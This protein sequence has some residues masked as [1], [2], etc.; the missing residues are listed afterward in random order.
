M[1]RT[2][3][4]AFGHIYGE[5]N[6]AEDIRRIN[7]II[8]K[9]MDAV[10]MREELTELK[11]RSDY[12]CTLTHSPTWRKRF[13]EKVRALRRVAMEENRKTVEHA[14]RVA[15]Q[16]GWDADYDPWG[17]N[18]PRR[19]ATHERPSHGTARYAA[20]RGGTRQTSRVRI[21]YKPTTARY[22]GGGKVKY[23]VYRSPQPLRTGAIQL[24]TRVKRL[25][26][27]RSAR[28][29]RVEA[30]Q[31]AVTRTGK[32]VYGVVVRYEERLGPTRARRNSTTY[33]LPARWVE[34]TKVVALPRHAKNVRLQDRAPE[35]PLLAVA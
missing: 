5:V 28:R 9:E 22:S 7:R 16:H 35:G 2:S 6:S 19:R 8:R 30:P 13:G 10:T 23:L 21:H 34:R 33:T 29:I 15:A 25:Y 18:E 4:K 32:R 31:T 24:R 17:P 27:P 12:L 1:A 3:K 26:F 20:R 11:K 14:N